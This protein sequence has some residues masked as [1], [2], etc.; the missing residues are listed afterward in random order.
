MTEP[1]GQRAFLEE[2][3]DRHLDAAASIDRVLADVDRAQA[4]LD[5]LAR[6]EGFGA[7]T[8][9]GLGVRVSEGD[10]R[11]P[12]LEGGR[13]PSIARMLLALLDEA[14]REW[15][16][17]EVLREYEVRGTPVHGKRPDHALRVAVGDTLKAGRIFR[18]ATGH[19][20]ATKWRVVPIEQRGGSADVRTGALAEEV[21]T[22]AG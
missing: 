21:A 5:A 15:T 19:Y 9:P 11:A 13:R 14:D 6:A 12:D 1:V 8:S 7:S 20:K 3:R 16:V 22:K 17:P 4:G 2:I 10:R 18:T